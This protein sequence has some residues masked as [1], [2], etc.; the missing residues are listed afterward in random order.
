MQEHLAAKIGPIFRS[1]KQLGN[2]AATETQRR[3]DAEEQ[4]NNGSL[5]LCASA[6][7]RLITVISPQFLLEPNSGLA[8]TQAPMSGKI[9]SGEMAEWTNASVLK[10]DDR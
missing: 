2:Q 3:R 5:R 1:N 6:P 7:L 10:T 4:N 9:A 8:L